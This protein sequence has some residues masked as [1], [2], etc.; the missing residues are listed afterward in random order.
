MHVRV[1]TIVL[2]TMS[3]DSKAV[4]DDIQVA[5]SRKRHLCRPLC[6]A[7]FAILIA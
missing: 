1:L 3:D 5:R 7:V 2:S 6:A 4:Q